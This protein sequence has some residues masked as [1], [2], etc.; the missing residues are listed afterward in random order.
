M[1]DILLSVLRDQNT[2]TAEFRR[3]SD[4]LSNLLAVETLSKMTDGDLEIKT[5][6]GVAQGVPMPREVMLVPIIRAALAI[7]PAFCQLLPQSP[8]AMIG[9]ERDEATALPSL[10]YHRFPK[11]LPV[12]AVILD[13]MLA[14]GGSACLAAQLLIDEGCRPENIYFSGVIAVREGMDRLSRLIPEENITVVAV[15]PHLNDQKFIVPGLGDYG[16]RYYGT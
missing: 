10:Y 8:V 1:S 15:D 13:P 14:T 3:A 7:L 4:Q 16:D 12:M 11:Y 6:V 9:I 5:P 2:S